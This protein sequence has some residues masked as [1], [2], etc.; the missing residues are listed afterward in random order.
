MAAGVFCGMVNAS[1]LDDVFSR[2]PAS[3]RPHTWWHWMNGNVT[4]E[5]I[6]A[7]L[8]AM[9][10]IGIGGAQIFDAGCNI[11]PGP[12]KFN[13]E[14]WFDTLKY[15]A[16]EARR[17]GIELCLPNCSGWS[18]SGGPWNAPSNA[19]KTVV[20]KDTRVSGPAK[21]NGKLEAAPN[22]HGFY[23]D[24]AVLAYRAPADEKFI[25]PP[26]AKDGNVFTHI[27][28]MPATFYGFTFRCVFD[29]V[30]SG[31]IGIDVEISD[32]GVNWTKV[33]TW[34]PIL[35]EGGFCDDSV[36]F[37]AFSKPLTAKCF[38]LTFE[39]MMG[40]RDIVD[41]G[42]EK[43]LKVSD[44]R[45]KSFSIRS[46]V[47]EDSEKAL[48]SQM[49]AKNDIIDL[50]GRIG[51]DGLL[52]WDVPEGDWIISRI[53][54]AAN[55]RC[56]H[57]ASEKGV[58]PEVDKLSASALA[59]HFDAYA[60]RLAKRLGPL[61]GKVESGLNNILVDS[62]EVGAQNWTQGFDETFKKRM[63]Y[64]LTKYLP[65][66]SG[67]IVG[68]VEE[69]ERFLA[70]YRRV[71]ADLFAEN[72]SGA[73][74]AKCHEYGL[75]LSLEPYGNSPS[76]DLQY[77]A[78][79][80][81]PMGEFWSVASERQHTGCGNSKFVSSLA[82]V[83]GRKVVATES[84]TADPR[85]GGRWCTT[86]YSIKAQT[87]RA[88]ASGVNRIIYHRFTHQPW[89]GDKYLPGM[90]M[91]RWGMHFDRTQTWW[92]EAK[93]WIEYQTRCQALLQEGEFVADGLFYVGEQVPNRGNVKSAGMPDGYDWDVCEREIVKR[94]IVVKEEG[95]SF[96]VA[97]G[98]TKYRF[99]VLPD[100]E[101]MSP[102]MLKAIARI[103]KSGGMV[104]A[105]T[106]P[107]KAPGLRGW[108]KIDSKIKQAASKMWKK[109]IFEG[110][111][112]D[113]IKKLGIEK[114][115]IANGADGLAWIHRR[116]NGA[117]IYFTAFPNA[118]EMEADISFRIS[119][120]VPELWDAETGRRQYARIWKDDGK[121]TTVRIKY[122][123]SGSM[124][125]VFREKDTGKVPA[126]W[127][128]LDEEANKP[129]ARGKLEIVQAA[130]GKLDESLSRTEDVTEALRRRI[131][132]DT[133][134]VKAETALCEWRDPAPGIKKQ[135][136]VK[137]RLDG[138]EKR[139]I[140]E[141]GEMLV[142]PEP[143]P[144]EKG[145]EVSGPW[146]VEFK[147]IGKVI[148]DNLFSWDAHADKRI[149]YYSGKATYRKRIE[150]GNI[151]NGNWQ[152]S[153]TGNIFLDL[154]DV[155]EF[156]RVKINGRDMGVLWRPPYRVDITPFVRKGAKEINVEIE[157]T[158]LWAN[159]LI[160]DDFLPDDCEWTG[161]T[162]D[163]FVHEIAIKEIPQWVKEGKK[164]PTGRSTFT[165]WKHW[166][167]DDKTLPSGM[168]GP[169][170]IIS[171]SSARGRDIPVA[172]SSTRGRDILVAQSSDWLPV[173]PK[174][175]P[176]AGSA[177]DFSASV[178]AGAGKYGWL[179]AVG[180]HF[181]FEKKPG[182]VQKFFGANLCF[183]AN[184]PEGD[185]AEMLVNRFLRMGY[186]SVRIHHHDAILTGWKGDKIEFD[187]AA[188]DKLDRFIA[189]AISKGLYVTTDL[190]VS[191][192]VA[193]RAIG[194]DKDGDM[195]FGVFKVL[196]NHNEKAF[197]NW[198][199]YAKAFLEHVNPYTGRSYKDEPGMPLVALVNEGTYFLAWGDAIKVPEIISA[200]KKWKG[201][202]SDVPDNFWGPQKEELWRFE[203]EA[204]QKAAKRMAA[205]VRSLGAKAL[206]T[207]NNSGGPNELRP[208]G[209]KSYDY[210]DDHFY[211]EHPDF[212]NGDWRLPS[213]SANE[214]PVNWIEDKLNGG[215]C[216][217]PHV[218]T[219]WNFCAPNPHR[220]AAGLVMG[221]AAEKRGI[222]G[223]WRFA[224]AHDR[225]EF[226]D[227]CNN[228]GFF[229][230][231]TD[232][233][234]LASE[235]LLWAL[236]MRG[237]AKDSK[238]GI[239]SAAQT[240]TLDSPYT[241]AAF[242]TNCTYWVSSLDEKPVNKSSRMLAGIVGDLRATGEKF[243]PANSNILTSWGEAEKSQL[244]K[245]PQT[246]IVVDH[247]KPES[248][249]VW[250][251]DTDGRRR[252]RVPS[253]V[254]DGQL[255]FAACAPTIFYEISKR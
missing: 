43:T 128:E 8:E 190:Y 57:P 241:K 106:K 107:T 13:S 157:V 139:K 131:D 101:I 234:A 217:Q 195:P 164:S 12:L 22:R 33:E 244:I 94:L 55:G 165:T 41:V 158:N 63:G 81:I 201:E 191:R 154:G 52:D 119:G 98:G 95:K 156:A 2:P 66:L 171:Q 69:S 127:A 161:A 221:I 169:V 31:T 237:D 65:V 120:L 116:S 21:F 148:F 18:S 78:A 105:K 250:A 50:T 224:Y 72:Y 199:Q 109:G 59:Y 239:N 233:V 7:D 15:T 254:K 61:A 26:M 204:E 102:E 88:Y 215:D 232:P 80:D 242:S 255:V 240:I 210:I 54:Y 110:T 229:D 20:W 153:H 167:K 83:W 223:L 62:Y 236:Y 247:I 188:F 208:Q 64:D 202:E 118:A 74:A 90:T 197:E 42:L 114:D 86:P 82:H 46:D 23:E 149:K 222:D 113:A 44:I 150:I 209:F 99:L 231:A 200:W 48:S 203:F 227:N 104:V 175:T 218:L 121:R 144:K 159:R 137:Y 79:A 145:V 112:G 37:R 38:R 213:K 27:G 126:R 89:V 216:A 146:E 168:L 155:K 194:I 249:C 35:G 186:N 71:V 91:G 226:A 174:K 214:P 28:E 77:G 138:V 248:L 51:A 182:V 134:R 140:V 76:D 193:W 16:K 4:K 166:T 230:L 235:R 252:A 253:A 143:L 162:T 75:Q 163:A 111:A 14:E 177:L 49:I 123:P 6:T 172:Q 29:W 185:E 189:L 24:I 228:L 45:A 132:G 115:V 117:E 246:K 225:A 170:K 211:Y 70:D 34:K 187:A 136:A 1:D 179:K 9:A 92:N 10:T 238:V 3:A 122:R 93:P 36:R 60:G 125:V 32:D 5:G 152:Y 67:R 39:K 87:D 176:V 219:E 181:E 147:G 30:W 198:A 11:P 47:E 96:L 68:S 184:F 100:E 141:E 108:P 206:L 130:L 25:P 151:G 97:P 220:G 73:L 135:L 142:L 192:R 251:L 180:D 19:M 160:G 85:N 243:D 196:V 58:G 84:Y 183:S 56:N 53:G 103:I 245:Y 178:E 207:N 40:V 17:L 124:F 212:V 129:V 205:F 173:I 133:L